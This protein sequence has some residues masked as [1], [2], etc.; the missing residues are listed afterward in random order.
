MDIRRLFTVLPALAILCSCQSEAPQGNTEPRRILTVKAT[1]PGDDETRSHITYGNTDV[2]N[3]LFRWDT[4]IEH[5]GTAKKIDYIA[6]YNV[7]RLEQYPSEGIELNVTKIDGRNATFE[8]VSSVDPSVEFKAGD[9]LFVNYWETTARQIKVDGNIIYDPR[10]IFSLYFGTESNK[11]QMIE[12]NPLET[13]MSFMQG[14]LK[15]YD[16]V[17][18]VEDDKIPDLHFK[19]LSAIMRVSLRNETGT[20]IYPTKIEFKYPGTKS[21]CNT[22]LYC[23][24]DTTLPSGLK[25]YTDKELFGDSEPYTDNIGTTING[26][27]G[28]KDIGD[29]IAPGQTYDLYLTTVPR[30]DNEQTGNSLT[31]DLIKRHDT[32]HPYTI[33]LEGFNKPIKAGQRYWF[34]LT[35]VTENDTINKLILTS[36]W[37]KAHP[38]AKP[39]YK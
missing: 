28:T 39:Y 24:V 12:A 34:N 33:T 5:G 17:T 15:M 18:V 30:I 8:S 32:D 27:D 25:V 36:E 29:S 20:Y 9:V 22:T 38:D 19:H 13:N 3:E 10:K 6:L 26:K 31:I 4:D 11:P 7:T 21:F 35:A 14:N 16:I 1:L 23:S 2:D 37:L